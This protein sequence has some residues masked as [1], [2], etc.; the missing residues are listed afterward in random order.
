[1]RSRRQLENRIARSSTTFNPD[2]NLFG[3]TAAI[4]RSGAC[5]M[6]SMN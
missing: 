5:V 6:A 2:V 4:Q 3:D 1:M